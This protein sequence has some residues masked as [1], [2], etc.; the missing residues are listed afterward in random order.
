MCFRIKAWIVSCNRCFFQARGS[1][2]R[3]FSALGIQSLAHLSENVF[4]RLLEAPGLVVAPEVTACMFEV[5]RDQTQILSE[6]K[7]THDK[8]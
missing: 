5:T 4:V 8:R 6:Q 2:E 3:F 7:E 1:Q